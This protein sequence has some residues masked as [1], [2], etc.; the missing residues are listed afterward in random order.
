MESIIGRPPLVGSS[1]PSVLASRGECQSLG[2]GGGQL[3]GIAPHALA[4]KLPPGDSSRVEPALFEVH[5]ALRARLPHRAFLAGPTPVEPLALPGLPAGA[6][7]VKRDERSCALYGGNKPR[8]LEFV[9]GD[10]LAR[11][12]RR[13]VTTGGLGTNHGLATTVL[14]RAAG[15]PTTLVLLHQ[16]I[17]DEVRTKLAL[18]AAWGAELVYGRNVAG[19]AAATAAVLVRATLR[20]ERP[21]RVATGG[22]SALGNVG[23]VSAGFELAA[24]VKA[25]LLPEPTRIFIA[26]GT[27]G[28]LAGL[29][30]GLRLSGLR[31]RVVGVLVTDILPP[32][33]AR[34]AHAARATLRL[35]RRA[36]PGVPGLRIDASDLELDRSQLGPGYGAA[37]P[38]GRE[39]VRTA[40]AAGLELDT[41]YTG[42]CLAAILA[43]ARAGSL[44]AGPVLFWN[45]YNAVDAAVAAPRP[46]DPALLP[47]RFRRLLG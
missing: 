34:L 11:R 45:T 1:P 43:R 6:L 26:V 46:P 23:F 47:E 21:Y 37:T 9:I 7:F 35:L 40:A 31:T 33:P 27:G 36:D 10:A 8:K 17:S 13:L 16:P 3:R 19:T 12:S 41:T 15:L 4:P 2:G 22:S 38:A 24:Q 25:G 18:A 20:G 42:K 44:G 29:L 28:T 32:S 14:G 5:P 30:V 39:A